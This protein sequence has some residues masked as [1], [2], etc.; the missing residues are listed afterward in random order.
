MAVQVKPGVW[1][2][3]FKAIDA[4]AKPKGRLALEPLALAIEKQAKINASAG[5]HKYGTP[6]PAH[7]GTGPA[8][9]SG[10][11]RRSITHSPITQIAPGHWQTKV[12]TAVGF[13]PSY[14]GARR[15]PAN[16]YG[17]YLEHGLRGGEKYPFLVPAFRHVTTVG[18]RVIYD[19]AYGTGTWRKVT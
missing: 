12:G 7:P 2:A 15:T 13:Y 9:I 18:A 10:N 11:L 16:K 3:V 4:Q 19:R 17:Y 6:T 5:S 8:V 1:Q 14:G